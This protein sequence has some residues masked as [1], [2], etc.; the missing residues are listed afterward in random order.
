MKVLIAFKHPAVESPD[1]CHQGLGVTSLNAALSLREQR[2]ESDALPVSGGE[3]LWSKLSGDWKDCTHVVLSAPF[4]DAP[5]L[6]KLFRQFPAKTFTL[7]YHS[8]LGFL[9]QDGFAGASIP[10]YVALEAE[11]P[12]FS[13]AANSRELS[14]A[15]Q[16]ATGHPFRYLPNLYHL[17]NQVRRTR[18]AWKSGHVLRIG[19]F[20][21][22]RVLKNWL[23]AGVAAMIMSRSLP[24]PVELH[25]SA[26]RDEGAGSTRANLATL[27]AMNP[28]VKLVQVPWLGHDDFVRYLYGMDLL[29][30]PS[31]SET[32]NGVTADGCSCGV[33]SVVSEAIDWVPANWIA[34]ADSAVQIARTGEALLKDKKA[35]QN[36]WKAL[37]NYNSDAIKRWQQ[38]LKAAA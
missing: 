11:C 26:G 13:V 38:W 31:F 32:F 10:L 34:K 2:I 17:P 1:A 18:E 30:Q 27:V 25:V 4:I 15:I 36:G 37:D 14:D 12:N 28:A 21:A 35:V 3:Y 19:L 24:S 20:G 7:V 23:T 33:P 22:S 6:S 9:T 5:F 29:F 16:A 8:N